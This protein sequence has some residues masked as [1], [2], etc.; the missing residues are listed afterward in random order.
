MRIVLVLSIIIIVT[1][2]FM[3][4][5]ASPLLEYELISDPIVP[6]GNV[7]TWLGIIS[8]PVSI[9]TG[10]S[11]FRS[12]KKKYGRLFS[13]LIVFSMILAALWMPLS[14]LLAD[15]WSANFENREGF[16]GSVIASRYFWAYNYLVIGLP[17]STLFIYMM[18]RL[19]SLFRK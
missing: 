7:L 13:F 11:S 15:N 2:S 17:L 5:T 10:V 3:L 6:L 1:V 14:Y 19:I 16:R 18:S 4:I 8:I 9:Y 12:T